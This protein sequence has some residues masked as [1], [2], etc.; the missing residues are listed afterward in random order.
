[1]KDNL[2]EQYFINTYIANTQG[3]YI[4]LQTIKLSGSLLLKVKKNLWNVASSRTIDLHKWK[5]I[6]SYLETGFLIR[7]I[8]WEGLCLA[9]R[10]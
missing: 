8:A 5:Q 3:F 9:I 7:D 1:M 10:T 4:C 6:A 2:V